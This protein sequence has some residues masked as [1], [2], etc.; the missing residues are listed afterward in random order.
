MN[1][2]I[3]FICKCLYVEKILVFQRFYSSQ[4]NTGKKLYHQ[5]PVGLDSRSHAL[6]Q[7]GSDTFLREV[8]L[9]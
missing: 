1:Q 3:G 5:D 2:T 8:S 7:I 4:N 9:F 6:S